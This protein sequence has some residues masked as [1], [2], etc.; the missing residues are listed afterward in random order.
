ME[1]EFIPYELAV[2]LKELGFDEQCI[3]FWTEN[4]ITKEGSLTFPHLST[5]HTSIKAPLWQQSF[6]WFREKHNYNIEISYNSFSNSW[7]FTY[8]KFNEARIN[9]E[10]F[11]NFISYEEARLE[12]LKKLI[13][14]TEFQCQKP[15]KIN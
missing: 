13:E 5:E 15:E 2:K 8:Y 12:C 1:K 3:G 7:L 14:L 4:S 9:R 6:D 10:V 11:Y